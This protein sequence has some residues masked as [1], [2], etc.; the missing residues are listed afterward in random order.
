MLIEHIFSGLNFFWCKIFK[1]HSFSFILHHY[2]I[3][4]SNGKW[5]CVNINHNVYW[6]EVFLTNQITFLSN[7]LLLVLIPRLSTKWM[8][9]QIWQNKTYSRPSRFDSVKNNEGHQKAVVS[10][11][12]FVL[13]FLECSLVSSSST[14]YKRA[15]LLSLIHIWRCRRS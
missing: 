3:I 10:R 6:V 9:Y 4:W 7:I 14:W 2:T 1:S 12:I 15:F 11:W 5:N 13:L 8:L